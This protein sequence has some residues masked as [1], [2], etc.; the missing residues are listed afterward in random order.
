MEYAAYIL[1]GL[2]MGFT[3]GLI[4]I[5]GSMVMIP[6]MAILFGENQHLYQA[7]AMICNVFVGFSAAISHWRA[8]KLM[9]NV[10]TWMV[11]FAL[12]AV[13]L[14][15]WVSNLSF[16]SGDR[17]YLLARIFGVFMFYVVGY[18][19]LKLY[20]EVTGMHIE[21]ED[22]DHF[23]VTKFRGGITGLFTGFFAGLLGIGA[24]GVSTP[25]QQVLMKLPI[26]RAMSNSAASMVLMALV[27]AIYKNVSLSQHGINPLD[28]LKMAAFLVPTAFIGGMAGGHLMHVLPR[29]LIRGV[30]VVLIFLAAVKMI[31]VR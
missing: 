7:S 25:L 28:S 18:N 5:G 21:P 13:L 17:S 16:F 23:E 27:G 31:T 15:V 19:L 14:G 29:R 6:L 22:P 12:V 11:P 4:G 26:R 20:K 9:F 3:G 10:L 24:G 2:L 30:F 8:G 1:I